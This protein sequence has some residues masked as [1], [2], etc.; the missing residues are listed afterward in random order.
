[1]QQRRYIRGHRIPFKYR[2]QKKKKNKISLK[3]NTRKQLV[4]LRKRQMH[5]PVT[6]SATVPAFVSI[7]RHMLTRKMNVTQKGRL[8]KFP[9][10]VQT[11]ATHFETPERL[12]LLTLCATK[13]TLQCYSTSAARHFF[14][15]HS[16]S[17][18]GLSE[19]YLIRSV[20]FSRTQGPVTI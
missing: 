15:K 9:V 17:E 20:W 7:Q 19:E 18:S 2:W 12:A 3:R 13:Q 5:S 4:R 8:L 14:S 1:M 6:V 11:G 16:K 10:G